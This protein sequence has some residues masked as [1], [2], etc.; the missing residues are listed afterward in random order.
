MT[1]LCDTMSRVQLDFE[2]FSVTPVKFR[3][4][5]ELL[6]HFV[7]EFEVVAVGIA[8]DSEISGE[9]KRNPGSPPD[10]VVDFTDGRLKGR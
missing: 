3:I 10:V 8:F 2:I 4:V 6:E 5:L 7:V 1:D 9:R